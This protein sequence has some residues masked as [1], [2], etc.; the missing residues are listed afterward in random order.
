MAS[1]DR[2]SLRVG[3]RICIPRFLSTSCRKH[4]AKEHCPN[5]T[6]DITGVLLIIDIEPDF[7]GARFLDQSKNPEEKETLFVAWSQFQVLDLRWGATPPEV[8]L[9]ALY[10][11]G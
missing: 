10:T 9:R 8:H 2:T 7:R 11:R 3:S 1:L 6:T 4:V 5:V